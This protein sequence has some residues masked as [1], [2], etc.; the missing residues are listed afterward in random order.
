MNRLG[1]KIVC[2][3]ASIIIWAQVAATSLVE[4]SVQL[5][6][7]VVGLAEG[8]TV[9][10]SPLP[11]K[12]E[13]RLEG[14][15]LRLMANRFLNRYLGEVRVNLTHQSAGPPF[16]YELDRADVFTDL[17]VVG[18]QP[19]VRLRM[20]VDQLESR[21]LP[22]R[23]A[24]KG[25]LAEDLGYLVPPSL[26]PDSVTVRGPRS[27]FSGEAN[28]ITSPVD[29]GEI[30]NSRDL[31]LDLIS[32]HAA[33]RLEPRRIRASFRVA[34]L[35]ER[36]L[37]NI[38]VVALVDA[39]Q[40]DVGVSPPVVDVLVRGVAD[41]I[42]ALDRSRFLVTVP[43]GGLAEGTYTMGGQVEYPSWVTLI[44][45]RPQELQVIVGDPRPAEEDSV[46]ALP[47]P[48]EELDE[49]AGGRRG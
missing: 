18:I 15:K 7:R 44:G 38:P 2:L 27:F 5:P 8:L 25:S 45:I 21:T 20:H 39:G 6:L 40:P 42:Q 19:P 14:S 26:S 30:D 43:V 49:Q 37:A 22:V 31:E 4:Q 47:W 3:V 46:P 12:V 28:I 9:E 13:V 24:L 48:D 33:L 34:E 1:L 41:S 35:Q 29:L 36:T 16:S 17:T 10:G 23:L 32:P 11:E